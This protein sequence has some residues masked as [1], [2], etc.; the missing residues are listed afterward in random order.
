MNLKK[1]ITTGLITT[2]LPLILLTG[3]GSSFVGIDALDLP[4]KEHPKNT[5]AAR[6]IAFSIAKPQFIIKAKLSPD[7]SRGLR[8]R[9][10]YDVN[11]IACHLTS[12]MESMLISKGIAVANIFESIEDMTYTQKKE[13]TALLYPVIEIELLQSTTSEYEGGRILSTSGN[14]LG[15]AEISLVM[16]EPLSK[17]KV[18][19]KHISSSKNSIALN[20][21]GTIFNNNTPFQIQNNLEET[22]KNIDDILI[23]IDQ[24][25]LDAI[26]KYI[27]KEE[28]KYLNEDIIKL[29]GIKRY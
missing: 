22:S 4:T 27:T 10:Q 25:I 24:Q 11:T 29:K 6:D 20:Y 3:C 17:E 15:K 5:K 16:I 26:D 18:W 12:E 9:L 8:E 28:F 2:S 23:K 19:V 7:L 13:S 14:L 1:L 21:Y